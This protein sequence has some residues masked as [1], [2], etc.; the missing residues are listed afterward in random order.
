MKTRVL[1]LRIPSPVPLGTQSVIVF[2]W[3]IRL[4]KQALTDLYS[5]YVGQGGK[6]EFI[7]F[8]ESLFVTDRAA[9]EPELN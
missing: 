4:H 1:T 8:M 9:I 6:D 2:N 5:I 3:W 7:P